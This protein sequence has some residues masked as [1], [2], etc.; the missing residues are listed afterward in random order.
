LIKAGAATT[1]RIIYEP[2]VLLPM[3]IIIEIIMTM[4][5]HSIKLP[6]DNSTSIAENFNSRPDRTIPP[7]MT[8]KAPISFI[9]WILKKHGQ[10]QNQ[11]ECKSNN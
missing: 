2:V 3:P 5:T 10:T 7:I 1:E 8:P 4:I 9:P 11:Q 6:P